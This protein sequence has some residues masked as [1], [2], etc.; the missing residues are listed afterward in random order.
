MKHTLVV[1]FLLLSLSTLFGNGELNPSNFSRFV[2]S[3][4]QYSAEH[5]QANQSRQYRNWETPNYTEQEIQESIEYMSQVGGM[6]Y[7]YNPRIKRFID[8]Y[9]GDK[10]TYIEQ[11]IGLSTIYFPYF[12]EVIQRY[13]LPDELKYLSVIESGLNP[14][15]TSR[16]GAKGL[17]Q[18]MPYTGREYNL[19]NY[20]DDEQRS[21][22]LKSTESACMF[23]R[24]LYQ[25][26]GDWQ[27]A[28]AAYNC[29]PGCV[30]SAIRRSK[31][32]D[33]WTVSRYLPRETRNYVPRYV[34][35]MYLMKNHLRHNLYPV[36]PTLDIQNTSAVRVTKPMSLAEVAEKSGVSLAVVK[37]LNAQYKKNTIPASSRNPRSLILPTEGLEVLRPSIEGFYTTELYRP[38]TTTG[39]DYKRKFIYKTSKIRYRVRYGDN[40][41]TIAKRNRVYVKDLK[42]WNNLSSSNIYAGQRLWIYK[43]V[44]E[45]VFPEELFIPQH[46]TTTVV[47]PQP[48][49][50]PLIYIDE[51]KTVDCSESLVD[52]SKTN[53]TIY[54]VQEG[55]TLETI[56]TKYPS[57]T[58]ESLTYINKLRPSA[59]LRKG[60]KLEIIATEG[61]NMAFEETEDPT[62][63]DTQT[64]Q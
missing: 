16:V 61:I 54:T 39:I 29:G 53:K 45:E 33:Y 36:Y 34:A 58:I 56:V 60:Q 30:R 9:V 19:H 17:W 64:K 62:L 26:F 5:L 10:R 28:L 48:V 43:K 37:F 12:E 38:T 3:E 51:I 40:L 46:Q 63:E 50:Q 31:S 7:S 57:T 41:S 24:D 59:I 47:T 13:D 1:F 49:A 22:V 15:A 18:F 55:E 14:K 52:F 8:A 32:T 2:P 44:R 11:M 23:L 27:L 20:H 42:K 35:F 25:Q 21:D 4:G 6:K